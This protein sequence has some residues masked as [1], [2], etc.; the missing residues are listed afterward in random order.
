M[1]DSI[2]KRNV[3][4]RVRTIHVVRPFVNETTLATLVAIAALWGIG[5]EVWVAKVFENT[6]VDIV[7]AT[8]FFASAFSETELV[9][10]ALT[11]ATV[12][13]LAYLARAF[14]RTLTPTFT[15]ARV[16]L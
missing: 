15:P 9:V 4:R 12:V 16:S 7:S 11:L 6:P 1:T 10:Q 8:R 13:A 14:V 3:M 5:R 2:L